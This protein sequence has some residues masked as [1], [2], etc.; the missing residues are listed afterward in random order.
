VRLG[1]VAAFSVLLLALATAAFAA[2]ASSTSLVIRVFPDGVTK[3]E[4]SRTWTLSCN[5][6]RGSLP[7]R[8]DACR[9]LLAMK[10]PFRP[11]PPNAVCTLIYG[12]PAVAHIAGTL[13]GARVSRWFNRRNGC[14]IARWER[15]RFLLRR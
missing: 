6:A 14:E 1:I 8:V 5:P 7:D 9:R 11:T 4:T 15:V 13:R 3:K 10:R 2:Q 12:G